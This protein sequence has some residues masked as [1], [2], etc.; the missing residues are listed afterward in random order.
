MIIFEFKAKGKESQ[1]QA[2]NEVNLIRIKI[3]I[4]AY[5]P[6]FFNSLKVKRLSSLFLFVNVVVPPIYPRGLE[7]DF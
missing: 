5:S 7:I 2:I 6:V 4:S 1:Y 3:T